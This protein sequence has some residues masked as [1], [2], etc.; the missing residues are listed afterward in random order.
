MLPA[1]NDA[2]RANEPTALQRH[3]NQGSGFDFGSQRRFRKQRHTG[4]DFDGFLDV[5]DIVE[6]QRDADRGAL[7]AQEAIHMA[8]NYQFSVEADILLTVE[9]A[10]LD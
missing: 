2:E 9:L 3:G 8:A 6:F 7:L 10:R 1:L 5:L 4:R